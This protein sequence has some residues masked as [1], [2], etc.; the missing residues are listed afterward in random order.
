MWIRTNLGLGRDTD[1]ESDPFIGHMLRVPEQ[2][3]RKVVTNSFSV[4]GLDPSNFRP[5]Y[6]SARLLEAWLT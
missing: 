3:L 1:V 5:D 2:T 4:T 6:C